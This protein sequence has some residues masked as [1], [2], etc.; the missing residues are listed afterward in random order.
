MGGAN[1]CPTHKHQDRQVRPPEAAG[2]HPR[3]HSRGGRHGAVYPLPGALGLDVDQADPGVLIGFQPLV[4][5]SL[6][7]RE[8]TP[9]LKCCHGGWRVLLH[10]GWLLTDLFFSAVHNQQISSISDAEISALVPAFAR[11]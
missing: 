3:R 10:S 11:S 6:V 1:S 5:K 8:E 9:R 7:T 2:R 4:D